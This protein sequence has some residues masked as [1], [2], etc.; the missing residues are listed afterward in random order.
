MDDLSILDAA[1]AWLAA[2]PDPVTAAELRGLLARHDLVALHDRFDRHLTFGT[3]GLRGELGAGSN[4][5]NRVIVRRAAR[6]LVE[7]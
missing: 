7:V 5:M 3:A 1:R 4:R 6:G 2:D